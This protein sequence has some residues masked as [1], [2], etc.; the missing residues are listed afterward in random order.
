MMIF[1]TDSSL[2]H[3]THALLLTEVKFFLLTTLRSGHNAHRIQARIRMIRKLLKIDC[4]GKVQPSIFQRIICLVT[5]HFDVIKAVIKQSRTWTSLVKE[6]MIEIRYADHF[7]KEVTLL[8]FFIAEQFNPIEKFAMKFQLIN[9]DLLTPDIVHPIIWFLGW[10]YFI[11]TTIF[12]MY[13]IFNWAVTSG[14]ATF[15]AW[16]KVCGLSFAQEIL[17]MEVVQICILF[18][19][20]LELLLPRLAA[21]H[22]KYYIILQFI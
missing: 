4:D 16:G 13:W 21:I 5:S 15:A 12:F 1:L 7:S 8:Q 20:S 18:V 19:A 22:I 10:S 6:K 14:T 3:E 9:Y 17:V 11:G 2:L